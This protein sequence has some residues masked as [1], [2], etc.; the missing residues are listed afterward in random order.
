MT[1]TLHNLLKELEI[2]AEKNDSSVTE[3]E[4]R[5]RNITRDTGEFL[6]VLVH[7]TKARQILE[8][9]T[10]NGYS[11]L[12]LADA[13]ST[14]GGEVTTIEL[15]DFKVESAARN[16]ARSGLASLISQI[17]AEAGTTLSTL[18]DKAYDLIFLDSEKPLYP[19][20]WSDIKRVLKPGGLLIVDNAISHSEQLTEFF[21]LVQNDDDFVSC[22]VPVGKGEFLAT[23]SV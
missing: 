22:L 20:W 3:R 10:S 1:E 15:S 23:K 7:A 6:A 11:T 21:P 4:L 12:W 13:V 19:R 9:G 17:H 8:V 2:F 14:L 18:A 5:M 16:F